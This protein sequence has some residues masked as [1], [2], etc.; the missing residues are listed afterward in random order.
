MNTWGRD[1]AIIIGVE[2]EIYNILEWKK[3]VGKSCDE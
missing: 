2:V 1:I 3:E